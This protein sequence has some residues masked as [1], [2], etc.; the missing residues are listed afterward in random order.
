MS[1]FTYFQFLSVD[2]KLFDD[3]VEDLKTAEVGD[4]FEARRQT[5]EMLERLRNTLIHIQAT[6][7][8]R[9]IK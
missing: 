7:D 2:D 9:F 5:K 4:L 1:L 6:I 3:A 8:G